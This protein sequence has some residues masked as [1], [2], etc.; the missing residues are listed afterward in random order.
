MNLIFRILLAFYAFC[1]TLFSAFVMYIALDPGAFVNIFGAVAEVISADGALALR[2]AA[3][4]TALIFF[5][6]SIIFLLSGV[7]SNKDKKAVSKHTNIGEVRISLNSVEN[8]AGNA[9]RKLNGIR[10]SKTSVK[11][12]EDGV[13]IEVRIVAM[14]DLSI[15][16]I[17]EEIQGR[18]K[19]AVEDTSGIVVK[20]V[21]VFVENIYTGITAKARVE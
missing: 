9:L 17:S 16:V 20:N 2:I 18:V 19:K 13:E 14:P 15:P 1:L 12:T 6:L 7:K 11:K 10:D 21:K 8:I 3:F 4:V 5:S